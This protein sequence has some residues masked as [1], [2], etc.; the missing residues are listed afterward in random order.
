MEAAHGGAQARRWVLN[1]HRAAA[2]VAKNLVGKGVARGLVSEAAATTAAQ[3][4]AKAVPVVGWA[5]AAAGVASTAAERVVRGKAPTAEQLGEQLRSGGRLS[6]VEFAL[7]DVGA[8][9]GAV[10]DRSVDGLA[11]ADHL[12]NQSAGQQ[13]ANVAAKVLAAGNGEGTVERTASHELFENMARALAEAGPAAQQLWDD[14]MA[15][16]SAAS[17]ITADKV[18]EATAYVN[19]RAEKLNVP[20]SLAAP[21]PA[22]PEA[23]DRRHVFVRRPAAVSRDL[24]R[25]PASM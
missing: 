13:A 25:Q 1:A 22:P 18:A 8:V 9:P 10:I 21:A 3:T 20:L 12:F 11:A 5:A 19:A 14:Y 15:D 16:W 7:N 23:G 17:G 24:G 6:S 4:A 2:P